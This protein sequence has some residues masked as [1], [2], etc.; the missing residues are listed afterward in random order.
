MAE[1]LAQSPGAFAIVAFVFALLVGS[2]LNVV[3]YRLPIMMYREW[4]EQCQ[5][6]QE[7]ETPD[8]PEQPFNLV[9]PRSAC[10]NCGAKISA[11]QNVPVIS[12]LLLRGRCAGCKQKISV[13]YPLVEFLTAALAAICALRMGFGIEALMAIGFD[14]PTTLEV[15]GVENVKLSTQRLREW[16]AA[17]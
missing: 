2:F 16:S 9:V 5:E 12:Y 13:R 14:G 7:T 10:P 6:L 3:I 11:W 1:L 4:Q 15:A 17:T 8:L